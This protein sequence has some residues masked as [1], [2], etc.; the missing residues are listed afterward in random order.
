MMKMKIDWVY[1]GVTD[2][3]LNV[4]ISDSVAIILGDSGSGKTFMF[5][6]IASYCVINNIPYERFDYKSENKDFEWFK[7]SMKKADIVLMDNADHT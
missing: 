2:I 5:E 7:Q 1:K 3:T 4:N 6:M